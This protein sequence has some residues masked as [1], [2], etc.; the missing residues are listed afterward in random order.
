[1]TSQI[2]HP[3]VLEVFKYLESQYPSNLE[4]IY[5]PVTSQGFIDLEVFTSLL[6]PT[7]GFISIMHANNET[8]VIQPIRELSI[9][10]KKVNSDLIFHTD[11]AQSIGKTIVDV[12]KLNVDLLSI[13]CHKFYGPKGIGALYIRS[14]IE[15]KLEK[16]IHGANHEKNLRAGTENV[17][18]IVGLGKACELVSKELQSRMAH[19]QSTRDLIYKTLCERIGENYIKLQGPP[20]EEDDENR[21]LSNTLFISFPGLE[22]NLILDILSEKVACSAG[23]ACHSENVEM[24]YVLKA[25]K[26]KTEIAMGTIR[27]ST[28]L[29]LTKDQAYSAALSISET[30]EKLRQQKNLNFSSL[31]TDLNE[32]NTESNVK[33]TKTTHGLGCGCKLSATTLS[34]ILSGLEKQKILLENPDILVGTE[35]SDDCCV[36]KLSNTQAI[37]STLDFF[38]PICDNPETFGAI[39]CSNALSDIYAMGGKP[40]F[41]LNIVG[42]PIKTLNPLILKRILKGAQEKAEEA[43]VAILGGHSIEDTEPKFGLSV[44]GV[45]NPGFIWRN[46]SMTQGDYIIITKKIGVGT[47]MTALKRG[48]INENDEAYKQAVDSMKLLNKRHCEVLMELEK[49]EEKIVNAC[50]DITGFGLLGH[51]KEGLISSGKTASVFFDSV[52][53]MEK[54]RNLIEMGVLP[55]GTVNNMK[56]VEEYCEYDQKLTDIEKSMINDPQTSGGLMVFI[57]EAQVERVKKAFSER[58]LEFYVIGRVEKEDKGK[59]YIKRGG[60]N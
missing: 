7:T 3:S 52:P 35:T 50:T 9:L 29:K 13:C 37:V 12:E 17:L 59:I 22:A 53:F 43:G 33:L 25:M 47:M 38:T 19:F 15:K 42:F 32:F 44:T 23:A 36:Y 48:I 39:A 24:S 4:V 20:L 57:G 14:G 56:F 18:E 31:E 27:L 46:S 2:E 21:R 8:G 34:T 26:V 51:L 30:V 45:V 58:N 10:A 11:A 41:A 55:G 54:A 6:K 1:M 49:N 60:F 40:L 28:G 16:L 5:L